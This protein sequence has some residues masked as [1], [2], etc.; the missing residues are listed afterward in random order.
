MA[1]YN[2]QNP[3]YTW[4]DARMH[5]LVDGSLDGSVDVCVDEF[6]RVLVRGRGCRRFTCLA[7]AQTPPTTTSWIPLA[8]WSCGTW[9]HTLS[10]RLP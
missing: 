2:G 8:S 7:D 3:V 4:M 5:G 10:A 9:A 6:M 1:V